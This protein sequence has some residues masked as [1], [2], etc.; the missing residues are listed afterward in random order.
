MIAFIAQNVIDQM[1]ITKYDF[2]VIDKKKK[3]EKLVIFV[4]KT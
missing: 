3:F 1:I 4:S 2:V